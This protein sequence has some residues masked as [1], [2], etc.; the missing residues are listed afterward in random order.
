MTPAE[1]AAADK[2]A[3]DQKIA[4]DAAAAE[5]ADESEGD[6]ED[7]AKDK[8]NNDLDLDKEL[9]EENKR[10]PDPEKA[11]QAFQEREDRRK[12]AEDLAA[13]DAADAD[14]PLT[15]KDIAEIER[16]TYARLQADQALALAKAITTSD[17]EA[18]LVLA[19]WRNRSFPE[20]MPLQDQL[21]EA[22]AI[23]HRK[24]IIGDRNEALRALRGKGNVQTHAN[25]T[26]RDAPAAGE[27]K[28]S[29]AD[30]T[31]LQQS[32]FTW[33]GTKKL[34]SKKLKGGKTLYTDAKRSRTWAL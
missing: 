2:A 30:K 12:A 3:A 31:A 24:K 8:N 18:Q 11:A 22:Y 7:E 16:R 5:A 10:K 6:E 9:E 32:G 15:R 20:T 23:T 17:K 34:Y 28:L 14:K 19:K 1:K 29:D 26:H 27:P 33:D 25:D 4:D 21:D 13:A